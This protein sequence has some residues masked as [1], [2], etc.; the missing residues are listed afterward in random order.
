VWTTPS[1]ET[2]VVIGSR[3]CGFYNREID[4]LIDKSLETDV[5]EKG[6]SQLLIPTSSLGGSLVIYNAPSERGHDAG[7]ISCGTLLSQARLVLERFDEKG[8]CYYILHHYLDK[9]LNILMGQV[10]HLYSK[11]KNDEDAFNRALQELVSNLS[12]VIRR[13]YETEASVF[14]ALE[15]VVD[16]G[17]IDLY[18]DSWEVLTTLEELFWGYKKGTRSGKE[19][20]V[21][22]A[23]SDC[24]ESL[25]TE[26]D[27]RLARQIVDES[28]RVREKLVENARQVLCVLLSR[29]GVDAYLRRKFHRLFSEKTI[30]ALQKALNCL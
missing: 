28:K 3:I 17:L 18:R 11:H 25:K 19:A 21:L 27:W 6:S 1:H 15:L 16:R 12:E 24:L 30:W 4:K 20:V 2:H 10:L 9:L 26:D 23:W 7:R 13:G 22:A 8:L 14:R 29:R 5:D